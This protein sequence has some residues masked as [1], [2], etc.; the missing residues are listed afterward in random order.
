[1]RRAVSGSFLLLVS[2]VGS[3]GTEIPAFSDGTPYST[4]RVQLRAAGWEPT[5]LSDDPNRCSGALRPICR[6]YPEAIACSKSAQCA[7]FW[8][9]EALLIEVG[10]RQE[11]GPVIR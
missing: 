5:R 11:G 2:T 3:L 1:M 6:E 7:F 10:T 8:K 4:A 9:K